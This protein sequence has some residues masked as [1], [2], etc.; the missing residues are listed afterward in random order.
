MVMWE[1]S[2]VPEDDGQTGS[3]G[4]EV[5]S[6]HSSLS[7]IRERLD[8]VDRRL[9]YMDENWPQGSSCRG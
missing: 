7:L 2:A 8:T 6:D 9:A 4:T 3:H 1:V 5:F